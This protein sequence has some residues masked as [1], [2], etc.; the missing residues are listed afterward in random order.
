MEPAIEI[1]RRKIAVI[2]C[3]AVGSYYGARLA[4]A[5]HDVHFLLRSDYEQ[6]REHGVRVESPTGN[7]QVRPSAW[8]EPGPIGP[9]DIVLVALKTTANGQLKSLLPPLIDNHTVVIT[10]QNGLGNEEEIATIV[11]PGQVMGG[12][13]FVCINR[14]GPGLIRHMAHGLVILGDLLPSVLGSRRTDLS[15]MFIKALV[16]CEATANLGRARWEKLTWNIPFNG[17]GVAGCAGYDAVLSGRVGQGIVQPCLTTDVLISD[18]R[19]LAM[20]RELILEV[21]SG[22]RAVGFELEASLVE[23]QLDRTRSMGPYKASTLLDFEHRMPLEL[24]TMFL[25]PLARAQKA[26]APMPCLQRLSNVLVQLEVLN[27]R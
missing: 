26:G 5:G 12:L 2:G 6:V 20:L 14:I 15:N 23:T 1:A 24:R 7:F 11:A 25:E 21:I 27:S 4:Q 8:R 18:P 17:L 3:G 10:L 16:P 9:C 19:W 13:C 22:A